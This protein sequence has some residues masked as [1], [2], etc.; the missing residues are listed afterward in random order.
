MNAFPGERFTDYGDC[1]S[2]EP[3]YYDTP[4]DIGDEDVYFQSGVYWFDDVQRFEPDPGQVVWFGHPG[5]NTVEFPN[6]N[7]ALAAALDPNAGGPGAVVY[8]G[9]N[10][11]IRTGGEVEFFDR[12]VNGTRLSVVAL[13]PGSG[14]DP[15]N[16]TAQSGTPIV[17]VRPGNANEVVF[18]GLVYAPRGWVEF[19]NATNSANNSCSAASWPRGSPSMPLRASRNSRS[20]EPRRRRW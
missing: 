8:L 11:R 6:P 14:Y 20:W 19:V 2:F 3:G 12:L 1:R 9:G 13:E 15:A 18:H 7:C 5:T 10:S 16:S 4:I 17:R